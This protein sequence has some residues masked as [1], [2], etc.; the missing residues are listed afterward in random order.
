M[1]QPLGY[2]NSGEEHKVCHLL[3]T[4]MGSNKLLANGMEDSPHIFSN[5]ALLKVRLIKMFTSNATTHFCFLWALD[6]DD[7]I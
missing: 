4:L 3:R 6:V 1:I 5:L 2:E 7:F